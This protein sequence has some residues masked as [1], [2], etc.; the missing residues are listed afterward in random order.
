MQRRGLDADVV[1]YTVGGGEGCKNES[2]QPACTGSFATAR[3]QAIIHACA[4][5]G[6]VEEAMLGRC[7]FDSLAS[8]LTDPEAEKALGSS[9]RSGW[10][11]CRVP[12][13]R[14]KH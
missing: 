9:G 1:T 11:T 5:T 12:A 3:S 13:S 14:L 6:K 8:S 7:Y 4:K 2:A 10:S